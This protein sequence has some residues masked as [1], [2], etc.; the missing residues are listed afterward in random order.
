MLT[1]SLCGGAL[2]GLSGYEWGR[3][4]LLQYPEIFTFGLFSHTGPTAQQL[5]ETSFSMTF[6]VTGCKTKSVDGST[7]RGADSEEAVVMNVRVSGPEPGYV[8]TPIIFIVVAKTLIAEYGCSGVGIPRG[9]VYTPAAAFRNS[10][11][12]I[13]S[14]VDAGIA[15]NCEML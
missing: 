1:M 10:P 11:T 9:G 6:R 2:M 3:S 12:I 4:L 8:A 15:F 13:Q 14:L 7:S 5:Q